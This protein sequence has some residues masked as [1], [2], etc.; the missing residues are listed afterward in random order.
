ML[1]TV[2]SLAELNANELRVVA[3]VAAAALCFLAVIAARGRGVSRR[4]MAA[5]LLLGV[6]MFVLGL[7]RVIDFGPWLTS[8]GRHQAR[9]EGWYDDRRE[10]QFWAV[11][12]VAMATVV[13]A[14][15]LVSVLPRATRAALPSAVAATAIV[16]YV[17][18]R[19]ISFHDL[20]RLL[21]HEAY[22][23]L[24]LNTLCELGLLAVFAASVAWALLRPGETR[25]IAGGR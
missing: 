15:A 11:W 18:L 3:Y 1:R 13:L 20:D 16:G 24:L 6:L 9:I 22:G 23:G 7:A 19:A 14:A 25:E 10:V 8:V 17:T 4:L 2:P 5:W 12:G 21:Y